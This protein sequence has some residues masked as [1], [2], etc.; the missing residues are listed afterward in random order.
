MGETGDQKG[1]GKEA[2]PQPAGLMLHLEVVLPARRS[3]VFQ[4]LTDPGELAKWWGP[5][6]FTSPHV[7]FDPKVG[8]GYRI[9]MQ[10]P[11]RELFHLQGE[12]REVDPPTRLAYTFRWEE[13]DPDDVETIV[14]LSLRDLDES[15]ELVLDQGAFA[16]EPRRA[17]HEQGWTDSFERLRGLMSSGTTAPG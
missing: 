10:P 16:T 11:D 9:A 17:L 14:T 3:H 2:S 1:T 13:P 4:A 8:G 12:F 5:H 7:E 15:T 6:G